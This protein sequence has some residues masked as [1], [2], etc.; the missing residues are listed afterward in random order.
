MEATYAACEVDGSGCGALCLTGP[1]MTAETG[2]CTT[3]CESAEQCAAV[4]GKTAACIAGACLPR[5]ARPA[6]CAGA[7]GCYDAPVSMMEDE[8]ACCEL[9]D[10]ALDG[11]R[12]CLPGPSTTCRGP[13]TCM[14]NQPVDATAGVCSLR[15]NPMTECPGGGRCIE[16]F[17]GAFHCFKPCSAP[18]DCLGGLVCESFDGNGDVCIPPNWMDGAPLEPPMMP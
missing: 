4:D 9:S 15:C 17:E 8:F 3:S 10:P 18:A 11:S 1:D 7:L 6:D 16:A 12:G 5:C 2:V 13:A 14:F